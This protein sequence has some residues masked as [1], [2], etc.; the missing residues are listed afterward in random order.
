MQHDHTVVL[1]NIFSLWSSLILEVLSNFHMKLRSISEKENIIMPPKCSGMPA[2]SLFIILKL[3]CWPFFQPL[4][5]SS[6][7]KHR[8]NESKSPETECVPWKK[9]CSKQSRN[10]CIYD[11]TAAVLGDMGRGEVK[12]DEELRR[13]L[14]R[15]SVRGIQTLCWNIQLYSQESIAQR[16]GRVYKGAVCKSCISHMLSQMRRLQL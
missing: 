11:V 6:C 5:L 3:T 7:S 2:T 12:W 15:S 9:E 16:T 10:T 4:L 14:K 13:L 1:P 8:S